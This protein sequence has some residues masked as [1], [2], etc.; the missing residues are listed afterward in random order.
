VT[1]GAGGYRQLLPDLITHMRGRFVRNDKRKAWIS[2][3]VDRF[4]SPDEV[5]DRYEGRGTPAERANLA[6]LIERWKNI[7]RE[8]GGRRD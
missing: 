2:P 5:L 3:K 7:V 6:S 8:L 1:G 4:E